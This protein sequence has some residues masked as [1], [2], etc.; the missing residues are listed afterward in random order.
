MPKWRIAKSLIHLRDQIDAAFPARSKAS[1]GSIGDMAHSLRKSDHNPWVKDG[2]T[3]V[4]T[5]IDITHSPETGCDAGKI[6]NALVRSKDARIKYIIWNKRIVS[7]TTAP[8][9]WR[10]YRG[11]NPHNKHFHIS[12]LPEKSKYDDESDWQITET[13]SGGPQNSLPVIQKGTKGPSV[14]LLQSLLA[15]KGY[16]IKADGIF[17][18]GTEQVLK[19]FQ[20]ENNLTPDGIAGPK[21]WEA[22]SGGN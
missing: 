6:T 4:V 19:L 15:R 8:W 9:Q 18:S 22:L 1:D 3:G 16:N 17:G 5:A 20:K 14:S 13:D 11:A 10:E 12:V 2:T 7:S 21:T